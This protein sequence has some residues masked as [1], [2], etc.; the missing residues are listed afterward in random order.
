MRARELA[1]AGCKVRAV[2]T[3]ISQSENCRAAVDTALAEYGRL[4]FAFNNAG[5]GGTPSALHE[6]P[7]D[8]WHRMISVNLSSVFYCIKYEVAAMLASGGGVI[9]N[10]SSIAGVRP[11]AGFS[12]YVAAK[13]GI[14]GL[15]RSTALEYGPHSVRCVAV[16][17]GFIETRMTE[18]A[19]KGDI[20]EDLISR[21]P[22]GRLGQ[23][24]DI[25]KAVR[26][27]C[28]TDAAYMNG[29]YIQVDGGML[30]A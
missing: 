27:L 1:A 13:H 4:D 10:N 16:G 28:S 30:V 3:D 20:R 24:E 8:E 22:L 17:P 15:T 9:I 6:M 23:P 25:A 19:L 18:A 29:A 7:D 5:I 2:T 21:I 14:I 11:V 26:M 12:H